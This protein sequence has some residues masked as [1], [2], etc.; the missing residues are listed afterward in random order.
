MSVDHVEY[1]VDFFDCSLDRVPTCKVNKESN[2]RNIA[3]VYV[4]QLARPF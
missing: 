1:V 3:N 2:G 4:S